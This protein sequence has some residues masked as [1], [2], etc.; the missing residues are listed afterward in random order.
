MKLNQKAIG[1]ALAIVTALVSVVCVVFIKILPAQTM[2]FFGWLIHMNRLADLVGPR[3]VTL[4][5]SIA[6]I[7][8]FSVAA[9]LLGWL[10]AALY[11]KFNQ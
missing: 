6:G 11:N 4:G 9:Y 7:V 1:S 8:T 10:F 2:N 3:E 5:G